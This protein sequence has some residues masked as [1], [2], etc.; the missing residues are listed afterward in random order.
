MTGSPSLWQ[1][2]RATVCSCIETL[3]ES[4]ITIAAKRS[5]WQSSL[6]HR[7]KPK[8][9]SAS[10]QSGCRK[11]GCCS[12][13]RPSG[14]RR[15]MAGARFHWNFLTHRRSKTCLAPKIGSMIFSPP[16][17]DRQG[18]NSKNS[19]R[20]SSRTALP[21]I[22][23][24]FH[25]SGNSRRSRSSKTTLNG[26]SKSEAGTHREVRHQERRVANLAARYFFSSPAP[27]SMIRSIV[28]L[29]SGRR[30]TPTSLGV[31]VRQ[32]GSRVK[33]LRNSGKASS[34]RFRV[35]RATACQ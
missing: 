20:T 30:P 19:G 18:G 25:H 11:R 22:S 5:G 2:T 23:T 10:C 34:T 3:S 24:T 16:L 4:I 8:L 21:N 14:R 17:R 33:T 35:T 13:R 9:I 15:V 7:Q 26:L 29:S 28:A 12:M 31:K 1:I 6:S 32:W 27:C